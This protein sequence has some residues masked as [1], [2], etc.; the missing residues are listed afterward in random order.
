MKDP[1]LDRLIEQDHHASTAFCNGDPG[2]KLAL[3]SQADYVTLAN[4]LGPP[5]LGWEQVLAAA[6]A[7]ASVLRDGEPTRFERVSE[8]ETAEL[9][10]ILEIERTRVKIGGADVP[11]PVA[12]RVT[13]VFRRESG[14]WKVVHRHADNITASREARSLVGE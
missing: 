9:A 1:D 11:S 7:A 13:T 5:A 6:E 12:L 8:V 14:G 3:Y 10:Y 2:P 4:P